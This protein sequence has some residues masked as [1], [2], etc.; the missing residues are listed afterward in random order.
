MEE[1]EHMKQ[2]FA[3][4]ISTKY[5]ASD[6]IELKLE[7]PEDISFEPGQF[8]NIKPQKFTYPFLRRPISIHE[9]DEQSL[10]MLIKLV[11]EGTRN[12][13]SLVQGDVVDVIAPLGKGFDTHGVK[14]AIVVGGGI[15]MAPLPMLSSKLQKEGCEVLVLL[16]FRDESYAMETFEVKTKAVVESIESKFVTDLLEE[17][18]E[19]F[20][21]DMIYACGPTPMLRKVASIGTAKSVSTQVSLEE[22]MGCGIGACIGCTVKVKSSDFGYKN[23]KACSDGPVFKGDEVIFDE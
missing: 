23:L 17:E 1:E 14:R 10:A 21:P 22:K 6:V 2:Y 9:Q 20:R 19:S 18:I 16:G 4:V 15:G 12:L 5:I 8:L 13:A 7:K 3:K 11:G